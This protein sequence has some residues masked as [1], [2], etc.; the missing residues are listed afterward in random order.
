MTQGL[1]L[2]LG[3]APRRAEPVLALVGLDVSTDETPV[4]RVAAQQ[5]VWLAI[6]CD[7]RDD[8]REI[9]VARSGHVDGHPEASMA[10]DQ[11][12]SACSSGFARSSSTG[13]NR[14]VLDGRRTPVELTLPGDR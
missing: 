13:T 5:P 1:E 12:S 3:F 6:Q 4:A 14:P 2:L 8:E 7:A 9:G 11:V 10:R